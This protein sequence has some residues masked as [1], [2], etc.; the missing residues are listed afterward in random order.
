MIRRCVATL[1]LLCALFSGHLLARQQG[2]DYFPVPSLEQRLLHEAR[3]RR[4]TQPVRRCG[5]EPARTAPLA[6]RP[7]G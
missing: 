5:V 7:P 3:L 1:L 2:H 4:I 6:E